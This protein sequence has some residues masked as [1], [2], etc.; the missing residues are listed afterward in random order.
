MAWL[1]AILPAAALASSLVGSTVPPYPDGL[2]DIGG[3]CIARALRGTDRSCDF[4]IGI[5][6]DSNDVPKILYG[7]RLAGRDES[8]H[9]LWT[10]TDAMPYPE[11][12]EGYTLAVASC[13]DNGERDEG[14]VAVVRLAE[15]EWLTE[16]LWIRRYNF[17]TKKF[18]EHPSA[19]VRCIN[20][21]WGL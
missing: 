17:G 21:G 11:V 2:K 8:N 7:S 12:P 15:T 19:G 18:I 3:S 20:E 5:L 16:V 14:I 6:A 10:I 9:A 1:T 4:S 13:Q